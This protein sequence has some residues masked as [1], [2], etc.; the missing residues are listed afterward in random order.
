VVAPVAT[1]EFGGRVTI[2]LW[3]PFL[4]LLL[5]TLLLWRL[6][7]C[8]P[9]PGHCRCGDNLT[10]LTSGRC[11]ECGAPTPESAHSRASL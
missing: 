4:A 2:P 1:D 6:E 5:P 7:R 11:P 10:G 8:R 3:I 9:P